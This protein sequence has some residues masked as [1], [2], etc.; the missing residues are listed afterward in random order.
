MRFVSCHSNGE[1]VFWTH[2]KE[3]V[4][5]AHDKRIGGIDFCNE[6]ESLFIVV[7]KEKP[8]LT[9][10]MPRLGAFLSD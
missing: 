8:K 6:A 10:F 9:I 1:V 5:L 2:D 7:E 4:H 3:F